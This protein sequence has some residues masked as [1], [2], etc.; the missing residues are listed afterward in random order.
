MSDS[1]SEL[2]YAVFGCSFTAM[3][4]ACECECVLCEGQE[5]E[6]GQ[7]SSFGGSVWYSYSFTGDG[8]FRAVTLRW[9]AALAVFDDTGSLAELNRTRA[10]GSEVE[11]HVRDLFAFVRYVFF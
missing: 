1:A 2:C 4:R 3:E 6:P 5:A 9:M 10:S 11:V 7:D 8:V